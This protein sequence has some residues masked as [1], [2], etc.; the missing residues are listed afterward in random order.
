L[1]SQNKLAEA[2]NAFQKAAELEPKNPIAQYNVGNILRE[3]R[4]LDEAVAAYRRAIDINPRFGA[5]HGNL[6]FTLRQMNRLPEAI[7]A[8]RKAVSVDPNSANAHGGLGNALFQSGQ[9]GE[10]AASLQKAV[11]LAPL[12]SPGR[13]TNET[14]LARCRTLLTLEKRVAGVLDGTDQ[15]TPD[16]VLQMAEMCNQ[17][18]CRCATA[19]EL[20]DR[21]FKAQPALADDL[22][23]Q[24]RFRA[25]RAATYAGLGQGDDAV[26]LAADEK[27]KLHRQARAWLHADLDRYARQTS[28]GKPEATM[29]VM[30]RLPAWHVDAALAHVYDPKKLAGFPAEERELWQKLWTAAKKLEIEIERRHRE[31]RLRGSLSAQETSHVH[32]FNVVSD[33]IYWIEMRSAAFDT[34]LRL[35]DIDGKVLMEND[36]ISPNNLNSRIIFTARRDGVHRIVATSFQQRGIGAYEIVIREIAGKD[37]K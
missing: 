6:S 4:R 29:Q 8:S 27:A 22:D 15:A 13:A 14:L 12:N 20:Y 16:D 26:K 36:D 34:F 35:T 17:Y 2:V 9:F 28:D 5:A 37:T 32:E 25:A 21:A 10:A 1:R 23:K 7:A 33:T 24:H 19:A 30:L 11:D 3:A 31:T 18:Q